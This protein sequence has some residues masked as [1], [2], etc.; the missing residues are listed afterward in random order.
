M[1]WLSKRKWKLVIYKGTERGVQ[2]CLTTRQLLLAS[3]LTWPYDPSH[4]VRSGL[5]NLS[6]NLCAIS[7]RLRS[8][9]S[10]HVDIIG[11]RGG[12]CRSAVRSDLSVIWWGILWPQLDCPTISVLEK[13]YICIVQLLEKTKR[14]KISVGNSIK[15]NL[16]LH[17]YH[18]RWNISRCLINIAKD[19]HNHK[20][21]TAVSNCYVEFRHIYTPWCQL[22]LFFLVQSL[23][24]SAVVNTESDR[25]GEEASLNQLKQTWSQTG[26]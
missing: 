4:P 6:V 19:K 16:H 3:S 18:I 12:C 2:V 17:L 15:S 21:K 22:N 1:L 20:H 8:W 23:R 7:I 24:W 13:T 14:G 10:L 25:L 26:H 9:P 11:R 5:T